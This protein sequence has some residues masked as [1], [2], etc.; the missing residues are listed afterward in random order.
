[1]YEI[2]DILNKILKGDALSVLRQIP[3][4]SIDCCVTSPPYYGLRSYDISPQIWGGDD[5]NCIHEWGEKIK[6]RID[7]TG[8]K[9]N[10]KG[11]NK[12]AELSDGNIRHSTSENIPVKRES[13][14]CT[15]CGAWKG[16]LGSEPTPY[17][18][19]EHLVM[20]FNEVRR[21]LKP[22]GTL[23]LNIGDSF[24]GGKG[25]SGSGG[26]EKQE[27]RNEAGESLNKSYQTLGG[28]K[29]TKP[30]DNREMLKQC[31][32]H[33]KE[34]MGIPFML[35]FA[36]RD[37]GWRI[38]CDIIWSKKNSMP[39]SMKDRPTRSHEY[40]FLCFETPH[41]YYD[42]QAILEPANYD[43]RKDTIM[44]GSN[45]YKGEVVP[46]QAEQAIS[47]KGGERWAN[48]IRGFTTKE[49]KGENHE[50]Q[51]HGKNITGNLITGR[52]GE[53]HSGY[54]NPDGSLRVQEMDGIPARNKRSVW[55]IAT[56]ACPESHYAVYPQKLII[57]CIKAGC[58]E[59]VCNK[60]GKPR[61]K[62]VK[63][64]KVK[65]ER[66]N[67]KT[68]PCDDRSPSPNDYAGQEIESVKLTDCGCEVGYSPGVVLDPFIGSGTTGVV[69]RK[70]S[71][72]RNWLG[73]EL[74]EEYIKIAK[75]R[76]NNEIG[77]FQ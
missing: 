72:Q 67:D 47:K 38:R 21:V 74:S 23:W 8:F 36:L 53:P 75:R 24:V 60:C 4:D 16:D 51:H 50:Q 9:R 69:A 49:N 25:Q 35:F 7:E 63:I 68:K 58:P 48:K 43:G 65:R 10:R 27:K 73:I 18:Y 54:V 40:I 59:E 22:T 5:K 29:M 14:I 32:L 13:N 11:L 45:K 3:D 15:K 41:Y 6:E 37:S 2:K 64:K 46:G 19:I 70:L 31:N 71:P 34:I 62:I 57:D 44:K 30:T 56:E 17:L 39:E 26:A 1:M 77:L 33:P 52:T 28:Q 66:L 20:I 42:Y 12:A 55:H 61:F 76:L